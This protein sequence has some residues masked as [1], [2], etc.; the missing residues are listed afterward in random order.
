MVTLRAAAMR[1]TAVK[2]PPPGRPGIRSVAAGSGSTTRERVLRAAVQ[3]FTER[4]YAAASMREIADRARVT[5]PVIYYYFKSKQELYA[6]LLRHVLEE[7]D[8]LFATEVARRGRAKSRLRALIATHVRI[9]REEPDLARFVYEVFSYPGSLPLGFD[10]Q[11][12][13]HRILG[14]VEDLIREGQRSGEFRRVDP[15]C[16]V[17]MLHGAVHFYV[18]AHLSGVPPELNERTASCLSSILLRGVV[19]EGCR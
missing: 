8:Q 15:T 11:A 1:Q 10:Y 19:A 18:A 6:S 14:R 3:L 17:L 5:K 12:L 4:G 9:C 16:A 13:G 2:G 7:T